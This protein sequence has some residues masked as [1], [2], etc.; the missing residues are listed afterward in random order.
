MATNGT[1]ASS[2]G[3]FC[4][5]ALLSQVEDYLN[6]SFTNTYIDSLILGANATAYQQILALPKD[7]QFVNQLGCNDCVAASVDV[8]LMDYPQLEN[9]TFKIPQSY[10]AN[11]TNLPLNNTS[12]NG[13]WTVTSLYEGVCAI[14]VGSSE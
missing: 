5:I 2:N 1:S 12:S 4:P 6:V 14:D 9:L 13:T 10:V 3:T 8:V 11:Y 7:T